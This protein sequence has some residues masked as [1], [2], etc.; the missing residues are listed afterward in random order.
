MLLPES[1]IPY[2]AA[3]IP[4]TAPSYKDIDAST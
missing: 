2:I 3:V 1:S 4:D